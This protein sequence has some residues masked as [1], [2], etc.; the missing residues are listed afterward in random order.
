MKNQDRAVV[1][2]GRKA[3]L[4]SKV[5]LAALSASPAGPIAYRAGSPGGKRQFVWYDR[6]GR[7]VNRLGSPHTFGPSYASVAP[8][9]RRAAVR[10]AQEIGLL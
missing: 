8:D 1:Q 10:R 6:T 7:E 9:N 3:L 4:V 2:Q 5:P